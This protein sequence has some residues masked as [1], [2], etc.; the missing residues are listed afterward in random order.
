MKEILHSRRRSLL[1]TLVLVIWLDPGRSLYTR[2]G[3]AQPIQVWQRGL[4]ARWLWHKM[5]QRLIRLTDFCPV[6]R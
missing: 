6:T 5:L 1:A 3:Y 2:V 4:R